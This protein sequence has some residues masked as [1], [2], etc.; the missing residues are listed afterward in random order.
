MVQIWRKFKGYLAAGIA[1]IS[2]PCHLPITLPIAISLT[3]GTGISAWLTQNT[4]MIGA[5]FTLVF[6]TSLG[7]GYFWL[8]KENQ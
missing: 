6:L 7:L 1:F 8:T 3:A 4:F 5:G 2:C